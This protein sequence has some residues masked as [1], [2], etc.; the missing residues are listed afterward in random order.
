MNEGLNLFIDFNKQIYKCQK[1]GDFLEY[2]MKKQ[3]T[4]NELIEL[5]KEELKI[6]NI[7]EIQKYNKQNR[8]KILKNIKNIEE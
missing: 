2:E 6:E 7:Q 8:D 4:D 3:L 1:S 5:I